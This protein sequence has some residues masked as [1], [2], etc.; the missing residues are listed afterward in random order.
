[1]GQLLKVIVR[2]LIVASVLCFSDT[3]IAVAATGSLA[4]SAIVL[5]RCVIRFSTAGHGFAKYVR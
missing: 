3:L 2:L 5:A 4:V 1:M